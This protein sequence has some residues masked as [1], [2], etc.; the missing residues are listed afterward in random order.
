M[1]RPVMGMVVVAVAAATAATAATTVAT[2]TADDASIA[3]EAVRGM[4][5]RV[6]VLDAGAGL[7]PRADL[8]LEEPLIARV[9][10]ETAAADGRRRYEI[11]FIGTVAGRFDLRTALQR[12]DGGFPA[13]LPP[14]EVAIRRE[15]DANAGTDVFTVPRVATPIRSRYRQAIT[16]VLVAW[17]AV[18]LL[19]GVR[20]LVR[21]LSTPPPVA[22]PP[23]PSLAERLEPLLLAA[24]DGRMSLEERARLELLLLARLGEREGM[25]DRPR[26]DAIAALRR[27]PDAGPLLEAVESWLHRP[28]SAEPRR[29][30]VTE[31]L[32]PFRVQ[33]A[34]AMAASDAAAA[35]TNAAPTAETPR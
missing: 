23:P 16:A 6:V 4:N 34:E 1:R 7:Q 17:A 32:L 22:E 9:V 11:E 35:G 29:R 33:E 27:T 21:R 14:I 12:P 28:G 24:A 8:T 3:A 31:L 20:R 26:A 25:A 5:G 10:G 13:D 19:V 18:P 2:A 15:L 30:R